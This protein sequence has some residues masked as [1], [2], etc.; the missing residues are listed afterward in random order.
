MIIII[1]VVQIM[2]P[3]IL[4]STILSLGIKTIFSNYRG[5]YD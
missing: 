5:E 1:D 3:T 4:M 2:I